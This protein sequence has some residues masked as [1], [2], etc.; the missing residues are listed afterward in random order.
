MSCLSLRLAL[1]VI[2]LGGVV[3]AERQPRHASA[4]AGFSA[5]DIVLVR[6]KGEQ[7]ARSVA[8][9]DRL[10]RA[11]LAQADP[12]TSLLPDHV[13]RPERVYR[14]HNAGADLYPYLLLTAH[15]TAP[16]LY[17]GVMLDM[18][19]SEIRYATHANGLPG[20]FDLVTRELGPPSMFGA[21]EYA[22]DGLLAVTERLGRTP[23]FY[24]MAD[25]TAAAMEAADVESRF[26]RLP[27]SDSEVNGEMLQ[28]LVRL[29]TMTGD[30]R[31]H[32]W[33]RRIGD[34]YVRDV[35][36]ANH[37]LPA[38][39]WDFA[40]GT[41]D[42]RLKLR[43]HGNEIVVGLAL[44][45]ALERDRDGDRVAEYRPVL[46]RMLDR[47]L[48]S[49]NPDGMLY[50]VID[51][52]TLEPVDARLSDNWGYVYGAVYTFFQVTGE[53][54]YRDAVRRVLGNL[55]SYRR[56][57]WEP[58]G[59]ARNDALGSFDGYADSLE[60]ALYLVNREP[61][62]EAM[63]WI[64]S[65]MDV[66]LGMQRPDGFV[67]DWY[68]EGNF[69][70]TALL[71][72]DWKSEGVHPV[73]WQPGVRVG[74]VRRDAALLLSVQ[75][76]DGWSGVVRFDVARHRRWLNFS[77]NYVRL[78]EFPEW[79]TVDENTLYRVGRHAGDS[80]VVRLG[81][82]LAMGVDLGPGEWVIEPIPAPTR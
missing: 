9:A 73:P 37:G 41:G 75:A 23:W 59:N 12:E 45:L 2:V 71:H 13:N 64:D 48:E 81:S 17:R 76:P 78:N 26:G 65:E 74:A 43:D 69:N 49:A 82:E 18:L 66:M 33:A 34:A 11:W 7:Y 56:Y 50:N 28:T 29:A 31:F 80:H 52:R 14:P 30:H 77:R 46:A 6:A 57:N 72:A 42:H 55:G 32:A 36:P 21:A 4:L 62:P 53:E 1:S 54:K 3:F 61:V 35:L 44:L 10:M 38:M 47:I 63:A 8:A 24:R 19:R 67:E 20:N 58:S 15:L 60:S 70:R 51:T 22:K 16:D 68:G 27:A 39:Q 25:L 40:R 5:D 79:F